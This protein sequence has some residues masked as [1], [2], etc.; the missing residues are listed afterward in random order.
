MAAFVNIN[1]AI[2]WIGAIVMT[3]EEVFF[4]MILISSVGAV[5]TTPPSMVMCC[6]ERLLSGAMRRDMPGG[7]AVAKPVGMAFTSPG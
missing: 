7:R 4:I 6:R 1:C 3:E 2:C 5:S